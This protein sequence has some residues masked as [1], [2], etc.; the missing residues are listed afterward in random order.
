MPMNYI[1]EKDTC[2]DFYKV[3]HMDIS[4]IHVNEE[5]T[6]IFIIPVKNA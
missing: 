1:M 6:D 5:S 2:R 3:G 4:N